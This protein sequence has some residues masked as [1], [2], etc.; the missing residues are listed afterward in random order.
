MIETKGD[1]GLAVAS[2]AR[3]EMFKMWN[4]TPEYKLQNKRNVKGWPGTYNV[5]L[6]L[7]AVTSGTFNYRRGSILF[8]IF[9]LKIMLHSF[10]SFKW[11]VENLNN[12]LEGP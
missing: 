11:L 2:D 8:I 4:S 9:S 3:V 5:K 7:W 10:S 6:F 12:Q 1:D